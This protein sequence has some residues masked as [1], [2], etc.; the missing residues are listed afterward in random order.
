MIEERVSHLSRRSAYK[1]KGL[2][3]IE[4]N[5]S[6]KLYPPG[7]VKIGQIV[8]P[9]LDLLSSHFSQGK[10][11]MPSRKPVRPMTAPHNKKQ[12]KE[13]NRYTFRQVQ[14]PTQQSIG[15]LPTGAA[16]HL[17]PYSGSF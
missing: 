3:L 16:S 12:S 10:S 8:Q 17:S 4:I 5:S 11:S 15:G 2:R 9:Q 14:D 6:K 1:N 13:S 7:P